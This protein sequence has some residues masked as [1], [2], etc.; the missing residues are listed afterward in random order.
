MSKRNIKIILIGVLVLVF[1]GL[2]YSFLSSKP[3]IVSDTSMRSNEPVPPVPTP[4]PARS[5]VGESDGSDPVVSAEEVRPEAQVP[6]VVLSS[7]EPETPAEA[8]E[9]TSTVLDV[10][11]EVSAAEPMSSDIAGV[12]SAVGVAVSPLPLDPTE[13][14]QDAQAQSDDPDE[15]QNVSS[16][17]EVAD[18]EQALV[19]NTSQ[20]EG[21]VA[22][23]EDA[24]D[25][26]GEAQSAEPILA[27]DSDV[28]IL[29]EQTGFL[30]LNLTETTAIDLQLIEGDDLILEDIN[31]DLTKYQ[32]VVATTIAA[33]SAL[34]AE[35]QAP[36]SGEGGAVSNDNAEVELAESAVSADGEGEEPAVIS[37]PDPDDALMNGVG[38]LSEQ[39]R[40]T[41]ARL[42]LVTSKLG[43]ANE[44]NK[45]LKG[46]FVKAADQNREMAEKINLINQKIIELT[47]Q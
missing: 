31:E 43:R 6:V 42:Q 16:D 34:V 33:Q 47:T 35:V 28:E 5:V 1:F 23:V 22:S 26:A 9:V 38:E 4:A 41:Y 19:N 21:E 39:Y 30:D 45:A 36:I 18:D 10:T 15:T 46:R 11:T 27:V 13:L 17:Q 29:P 7:P 25:S 44:K 32:T 14:M 40:E 20:G 37:I 24:L 12:F 2:I 8:T 3:E